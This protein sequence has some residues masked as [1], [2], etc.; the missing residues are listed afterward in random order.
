M[1]G[2][3]RQDVAEFAGRVPVS[4]IPPGDNWEPVL[5]AERLQVSGTLDCVCGQPRV[6]SQDRFV[7]TATAVSHLYGDSLNLAAAGPDVE[8]HTARCKPE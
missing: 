1:G 3:V 6:A 2:N 7:F 4:A 5:A 8:T